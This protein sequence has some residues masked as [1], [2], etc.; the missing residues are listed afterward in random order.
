MKPYENVS[1]HKP[2]RSFRA[3]D[4]MITTV[5]RCFRLTSFTIRNL[6]F[7][8]LLF[9]CYNN[10]CPALLSEDEINLLDVW[11]I[12]LLYE[13][14]FDR[15]WIASLLVVVYIGLSQK[16]TRVSNSDFQN[17]QIFFWGRI[18]KETLNQ[19][20]ILWWMRSRVGWLS[21]TK[22]IRRKVYYI[23]FNSCP[24]NRYRNRVSIF[25]VEFISKYL[26]N[27]M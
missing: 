13:R 12:V 24:A 17:E 2:Q 19:E 27:K 5:Y 6:S 26:K 8:F 1:S 22:L 18:I 3:L 21:L 9:N 7:F 20:S 4:T 16:N 23:D 10:L 25:N 11:T 14:V 15:S